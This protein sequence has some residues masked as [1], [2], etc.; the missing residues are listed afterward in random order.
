MKMILNL[1]CKRILFILNIY[2]GGSMKDWIERNAYKTFFIQ[3]LPLEIT[4]ESLE[5]FLGEIKTSDI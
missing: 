5:E 3:G 4:Q 2:S 1:L